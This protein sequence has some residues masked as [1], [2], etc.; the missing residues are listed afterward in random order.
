ML[1]TKLELEGVVLIQSAVHRDDR[2]FLIE[3]FEEG[4]FAAHSLPITFAQEL[5]VRSLP[6]VLR[7]LHF[8]RDPGQGKL[9]SVA[10][11]LSRPQAAAPYCSGE[12]DRS[13][14]ACHR[15]ARLCG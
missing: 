15:A 1:F 4:Q 14:S 12:I 9:V 10:P 5:H 8:Q 2:G 6:G 7:G 3:G 13:D 11:T